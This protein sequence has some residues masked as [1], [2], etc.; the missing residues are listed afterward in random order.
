LAIA[1]LTYLEEIVKFN[2][3]TGFRTLLFMNLCKLAQ[4]DKILNEERRVK[5]KLRVQNLAKMKSGVE[6]TYT[7]SPNEK[8]ETSSNNQRTFSGRTG[9]AYTRFKKYTLQKN[10][11]SPTSKVN[12]SLNPQAPHTNFE[13]IDFTLCTRNAI[14]QKS[15]NSMIKSFYGS[16][17]KMQDRSYIISTEN[18]PDMKNTMKAKLNTNL[19]SQNQKIIR[20]RSNIGQRIRSN[21]KSP[22]RKKSGPLKAKLSEVNK[23]LILLPL[24]CKG[25]TALNVKINPISPFLRKSLKNIYK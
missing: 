21:S 6:S 11:A 14:A 20:P 18:S 5:I 24:V 3:Q 2:M 23:S 16:R 7:S 19:Q 8:S 10:T 9:S 1:P 4:N 12:I 17:Q 25:N 15:L 13:K 22:E